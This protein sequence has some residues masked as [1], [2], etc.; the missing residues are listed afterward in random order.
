[1]RERERLVLWV[2]WGGQEVKLVRWMR[3]YIDNEG[4]KAR[5]NMIY[6]IKCLWDLIKE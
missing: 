2:L 4:P 3:L 6:I 5:M 1:M